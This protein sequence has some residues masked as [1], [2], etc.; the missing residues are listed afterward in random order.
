ML[1]FIRSLF[2]MNRQQ[3]ALEKDHGTSTMTELK[4]SERRRKEALQSTHFFLGAWLALSV[5]VLAYMQ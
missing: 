3:A 4:H 2:G 1:E 5:I